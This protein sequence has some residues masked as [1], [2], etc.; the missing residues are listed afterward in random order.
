MSASRNEPAIGDISLPMRSKPSLLSTQFSPPM[1]PPSSD[2][3]LSI[4]G[5][6]SIPATGVRAFSASK[7]LIAFALRS[8]NVGV[9][10]SIDPPFSNAS[11]SWLSLVPAPAVAEALIMSRP[12]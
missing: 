3:R 7:R 11:Y 8:A 1:K 5:P 6:V 10:P 9:L 2:L 12:S 4:I